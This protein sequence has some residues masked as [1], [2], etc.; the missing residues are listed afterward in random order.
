MKNH[1]SLAPVVLAVMSAM[2]VPTHA[3][4]L[5]TTAT[6]MSFANDQIARMADRAS[7]GLP[8]IQVDDE[9]W[10]AVK[11]TPGPGTTTGV[12]GY[13]TF[14][15][16]DGVQVVDVAYAQPSSIDA[17]G[18]ATIPMKGQSPIAI[19]AGSIGAK[20]ATGLTG[21]SYPAPN[22]LGVNEAPVTAGGLARG[23]IS[24]VYADTGIFYSTD[25][26]TAFNSYGAAP[27]GGSAPMTNNSGDTVGEWVAAG[28]PV[29]TMLGVMTLWDSYQLRAFGR[30]NSAPIIDTVDGRGNAPWGM[31]C[32]VAGPQSGYAWSFNAAYY[33]ANPTNANRIRNS[34]EVGPWQRVQYAGSQV[35][36]DQAGLLSTALGYSG[37]DASGMGVAP[38][39]IPYDPLNPVKAVRFAI[40]QLEFGRLEYS[41][42]KIRILGPQIAANYKMYADAF[43]G[44]AG[45]ADNGKDHIW[46]YFDPTVV[47]L[48]SSALLQK[49]AKNPLLAPGGTTSFAITFMNNA[50]TAMP[51]VVLTDT[52]PS[53]LSYLSSSPAASVS[54]STLTWS[55]GTVAAGQVVSLTVNV[56]ATTTGT[57]LNTVTATS[58]GT[59]VAYAQDTVEIGVRALLREVKTVTPSSVAP[60]EQVTYT[61]TVYNEGT[62]PNGVPMVVTDYLPSGFTYASFV[63]ATVNGA[64]ITPTINSSN[65]SQPTF[66]V[67]TAIQAGKTLVINFKALVG[68]S[69]PAG[70][71]YNQVELTFEGK[72]IPPIPEAP[73]IVTGGQIGG[74]VYTDT[75]ASGGQDAG[76]PGIPAVTVT[77]Y[78][79]LNNN[80][81]YDAGDSFAGTKVTDANGDYIFT[82]LLPGEYVVKINAPPAGTNTGNPPGG[83]GNPI[84][85]GAASLAL[86]GSVSNIDFGYQS[87]TT[88]SIG[89]Q[90]FHDVNNNG[91]YDAGDAALPNVT[92]QLYA[93]NGT[94]LLAT[95]TT[96]AGGLYVFDG[97]PAAT[98]VVKVDLTDPDLPTNLVSSVSA[99][100]YPAFALGAGQTLTDKDFPFVLRYLNKTVDKA[101]AVTGDILTFTLRSYHPGPTL[102]TNATVTDIVPAGTTYQNASANAGGSHAA[103]TVTWNLGSTAAAANGTKTLLGGGG[104]GI[105]QRGASTSATGSGASITVNKPAGVVAGDVMI[106]NIDLRGGTS[107][108]P[109]L[110]G[111]ST[112]ATANIEDGVLPGN[113]GGKEHRVALLYRVAN[114]TE[115]ASFTFALN[116]TVDDV[117]A[118]I[119][120]FSGVAN[121]GGL[122]AGGGPGVFD[123]AP[124][125]FSA[126]TSGPIAGVTAITTASA[127]AL[128]LMFAG[129]FDDA[130]SIT[131]F[132]TASMGALDS[133]SY[134]FNGSDGTIGAGWK[135]KASPGTTG[136]GSATLGSSKKW[137]AILLALRP[138][139]VSFNT[140]TALSANRSLVT[141]GDPVTVTLTVSA[142]GD[143]GT[144]TAGALTATGTNGA[145][146][147][148][149]AASPLTAT[150]NNGSATFTYTSTAVT[151]GTTPGVLTFEATPSGSIGGAWAKGTANTV[152][153]APPL[154]F[155][156]TV[157]TNPGVSAVT[158]TARL[159]NNNG[160]NLL[161]ESLPTNTVL[162]GSI[163]DHVWWDANRDQI[164]DPTELPIEDA[165]AMLYSDDNHNGIFDFGDTYITGTLTDANGDYSFP[166]LPAGPY[167]VDVYDDSVDEG[168]VSTT[169]LVRYHNLAPG[170]TYLGADFGYFLGARIE[171]DVFWDANR[172]AIFE[173][174]ETGL[175]PVTVTLNGTDMFNS[176]VSATTPTDVAG[177]F[178]FVVPEG[179]YTLTYSTPNVLVINSSLKDTT[180]PTSISFHA[181][182]GPYWL[183]APFTFGVDNSGK[184]GGTIF[185]DVINPGAL[186]S[187]EPGLSNITVELYQDNDNNNLVSAG[188]TLLDIQLTDADG[189]YLF[190]GLAGGNYVVNVLTDILSS[191]YDLPPTA[192]PATEWVSDSAAGATITLAG[193][194][195]LDRNFGYLPTVFVRTISGTVFHDFDPVNS[196]PNLPAEALPNVSVTATVDTNH[197]TIPEQVFTTTTDGNGFYQF[198]A[199]PV[200]CDAVITVVTTTLPNAAY[201]NT[202]DPDSTPNS[203]TGILNITANVTSQNFGYVVEYGSIAGTVVKG[204]GDGLAEPGEPARDGV[205]V[206]LTYAGADGILGTTTDDVI[207]TTVT[208]SN[209]DYTFANLLPGTYS[210]VTTVPAGFHPYADA[211]GFNPN[212][213]QLA[214]AVNAD[215]LNQDFEYQ[216]GSIGNSVWLDLNGNSTQDSGEPPL[217]N[218]RVYLDLDGNGSFDSAV[219]PNTTTNN[220]G[221][222]VISG[223]DAV[224]YTVRVDT[225]TLPPG[226]SPTYDLDGIGTPNATSVT[227][228]PNQDRT[229]VDFGYRGNATVTGH[230]YIDTNGNHSQDPGEPNLANVDVKVTDVLGNPQT[231]TTDVNGNW[232]VL[233]I[234]GDTTVKINELDPEYP[235][236]YTQTEGDD[237]TTVSAVAAASVSAGNDGFFLPGTISGSVL[238]D[239]DNNTTGDAPLVN[240]TITLTDGSGN[241]ID[242]DPGTPG[243]QATIALTDS[244][245]L[246]SFTNLPPGSYQVVETDPTGYASLTDN[247]VPVTLSAGGNEVANFVDTQLADL[248]ITKTDSTATYIPGTSTTY[249]IVVINN[250][251]NSVTG[252]TVADAL[253]A[254]I[255]SATWTTAVAGGASVLPATG[256]NDI[257]GTLNLPAGSSVTYT[258]VA[259]ISSSA[260]ADLVNTATVSV[261]NGMIDPTSG[262]NTATDTDTAAPQADLTI[263]KTDGTLTYVPGLPTTYTIIVSNTGPSAV[264]GA[265]VADTL[266]TDITG[267]T[268]TTAVT[269]GASVV[270]ATGTDDISGTLNLPAGSSVTY[271]VIA[272]ISSSATADLIN[273]ATVSVPNGVTDTTPGNNTA[274]DTDTAA[275]QADLTISKT[276]GTLTYVPGLPTTYTIIVSNTGPSA[277]TGATVADTL[278][279]DITGATWTTAVAGGASVV[280]ATGSNDISGTLNLPAGSSVTY[281]VIADISSSAT[282]DLI[283]TATVSVPNGVTDTTPGNNTATDTDT[284]AP[285]ADLTITK[286]DGTLTYVPGLPTTYTIIVSNTGPSA[287]TGATVADTLPTD[288]TGA[289][290][291]T[292]VAGGASVVPATGTDDISGTLN[293]PAGSSVTYTVIAD[294]SSSATADLINTAT[295]S[296]PNGVT[297]TTPGNNTAT[298]T[299]TAAPQADLTISKTDGTL[300]YV[301]GLPT[302]YTI[303]VSNTG[304]SAVTGATVADTLP[305]DITGATWTTAVAGGASVVPAT[306]TDDISGTLNLPAGSSVTY[307]VMADISSSATADLINTA[308]VSVPNGVTDTTPGNNT[309]TDTDTAAPQADLTIT[310]TDGTLTYVPGLP[311]TYTIIVSNTGPS[312]V[313]GATVADT[314]P[315]DITGATWTTAVAGGASVVPATGTDDISGTLNLPAGS[316]VT[317]TVIADISSS[318]TADLINTATV[319]VPNGVTDTTPGNNTATDTDTAAPQAD[320]TISKTDGTLTYVPGL[321]T[322]YTIIVSNTG[323]SAVTGATVADTLPTD[324]TGATWTT[325]VAGGASVVPATGT[326]DI[327]GTL[328][329]PA[330]SSVT[331]TVIADI[332]SS[333][334]ADLI[335]TATVSV[336]NGVTDTTPGNN[337]ATDTDT[338]APQADLTISKT[339]GTLTYVPGLPTT[340][341]IIVSNTGPSAVTG[342]TVA[343]TL[344]TDITGATW[345]TAVAGGA[346]VVPATGTDDIS[347][348]LNLPAGSSVTYT[349]IADISSSAT[350]DLINTATV[351]VPNGVTD[352]TPGN[353][354]ATDT[355]TAAPQADLTI[356]KTD[357]TLTYVPGL[358]TTYTIIVSNTGPSAV[359][360]ATVADTLPTDITGATWTTAVAGGASVVPATGSNDISGTLNLPAGSSVT[361]TVIADISSSATADLI[362]TATVSVPNGVTDTTPG[363]NTATDTDTAAPQADLTITKTDGTLTYVPGLPTT[364]TIIVSNTGPSAVTGA[365]VAD[366]LPTDITGAT[367]TTAVAGGASVVPATG[368]DDISGTL[369]LPAGSSVTYTVIADISSSATA[370]LINTA[371]VSVP[372]GVTDTT[373]GNNTATDTDTAAPQA[374]LTISKTDGTL[375]YVPGLPTTYT[376]IVSNTGPS[377]VTGATVA[378]TLPTDI[379]G[380]TWTTAV[381]GGASVVPAT[382]SNDISGTLNLP[383]GSSVTYTV[384]ADISSSATADLIN[385]A[386]VSVPNGVTDTTPGNNTATDTD[387][388]APQADLTISKT[389]GTLTYVPGL[390]TTYTIIVSNTGPSA[391]TGATVADTLPTDITGA[392]WTTAVAGGASVVP[393]TGTDDI[394][395]TLNLPAGSSVTYTVIADISSSATADLINTATVSVPNGVTDTTPGNNTATDTDTAAPQADLT[396]SKTDGTLTYV[397]G[398]PT[399]YTII[400]S[401]TGPSA[402]TG[403]TVADTLPT[404]ITGAT[405]TTAV[406]GGAS[407]VPA[408]GSN[409]ISGTLN[410]PAGSSVTYTVIAD[411]SSSATADLVNTAT[412]SVPNGVTDTTPGN[413]TATDTD[414]A[415]P[416]ADLTISKT[417]GTL[418]Y[419]PG[420]PTTYTIIVSNT[421]P[422]AVT[423]ATVADT[424]PTDITGAT[425]TT[426]VTGGASVVPAT[427]TDDISGTLNL[428]A[429]SSVTY[430]VIADISSSATADLINTATVSVPNG[431]TDTT[432]GNNT[433]T[434]T[435]TAAPQADLTIT[436]TDGTLTYVPGLPTTYTIIVRNTGPSAVTGATVADTLPTDITGATWTTAVTGGASVLP[437]TGSNDISG[438]LNLP[439]NSSVTYTVVADISSSATADLVN[440][441][442]VSVPNGVT[443]T[444]PGNNTATDTDTAAPQADLTI[445]KTDGTLTYVPGLPTTYTIIVSNTGP[446]AVT[447]ATVA[448]TLPTDITGATWTT[449]V[450]GGASVVPATGTDDISG[451]L[452]LPAGSSVTYTVIADISSSATADLINTATVS[453]PN[454]VTD[455]TPG[456]NTATDT[457]TATPR[458]DLSISKTVDKYEPLVGS[459][460]VFTLDASNIGPSDAT[461]VKVTDILPGGYTFVSA[462]PLLAYNSTTGIW[463]IGSLA[464]NGS[465]TL[466]ITAKVKAAGS[467]DNIA[468]IKGDQ[469]DPQPD[470]DTDN[471]L[472]EP[473]PLGYITGSV[474]DDTNNDNTSLIGIADVPLAL[475]DA[476]GNDI[477]S[478]PVTFGMQP[479]VTTTAADGS[480]GFADLPPGS[481]RVV[482]T[483]PSGYL[484]V[485][486]VDGGN[487]DIIGDNVL[488]S[489][490]PGNT[491]ANQNFVEVRVG[492]LGNMVWFDKNHNGVFDSGDTGLAGVT[493]T[494]KDDSH[495]DIDSDP[496]APG[497]QPTSVITAVDGTYHFPNLYPGDYVVYLPATPQGLPG[498]C[499][500]QNPNDDQKDN[501]NNGDQPVLGGPVTSPVIHIDP[502]ENDP[503]IDIGFTCLGTW[504]EWQFLHP[505]GGNNQPGANPDSDNYDNL[506]EYAFRLEANSGQG[507][508]F[509]LKPSTIAT[510]KMEFTFNRPY[511]VTAD[512]TYYLEYN[513]SLSK[514]SSWITIPLSTMQS[515]GI[516]DIV[517]TEPCTETVTVRN[518]EAHEG[519]VRL[520]VDLDSNGDHIIERTSRTG[521][522][523]WTESA[524]ELGKR[525]YNNPYPH[526]DAFTGTVDAVDGNKLIFTTSA[527][528]TNM[529]DVLWP[530]PLV[531]PRAAYYLE[532]TSGDNE[533]QRFDVVSA[534][535]STVTLV[536]NDSDLFADTPPFNTRTGTLPA[537]LTGARVAIRRHWTLA[538]LFPVNR[539]FAAGD[540]TTADQVQTEAH[541]ITT[542]YWLYTNA[543][544]P[545]WAKDGDLTLTDRAATVIAPGQGMFVVKQS[546][547]IALMA[548]GEVRENKFVRPLE[549]GFNLVGGGYP[550]VQSATGT[551]TAT[552][553]VTATATTIGSRQMDLVHG[554]FGT[555]DFATADRFSVWKGDTTIGAT[556]YDDYY[557]LH[558]PGA[559]PKWVKATDATL[560]PRD[561]EKL[562]LGN[563]SVRIR[564][565]NSQPNYTI[566]NPWA[567]EAPTTTWAQWQ[568]TNLAGEAL[569][570]PNDDPDHDGTPNLLEY[571]FGTPSRVAQAPTAMPL[572]I[573]TVGGQRFLQITIPRL[574]DHPAVLSVEVSSDLTH[575]QA[576]PTFTTVVSDG[577]AALV[578]R[579]LTPLVAGAPMRFMRLVA[580]VS[581]P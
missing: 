88:G 6:S 156:A 364:Y 495:N 264:T 140:T 238:A 361:Y 201:V 303:I 29:N 424:L 299:D 104:G 115:G 221:N 89:D 96:D 216:A 232:S 320:L 344:P 129:T 440:T 266:P 327:S 451:T 580:E 385:T 463:S 14:Y 386:T 454:G 43:G 563:R 244:N 441:A 511:G 371:T 141:S 34:I 325:A 319:S 76:E 199:I 569:N 573:V 58:N 210:I 436:K 82:G 550:V 482:E 110:A 487:L 576:G 418:T 490:T 540:S 362:N 305:T 318:A 355:D 406:A 508:P 553:I 312:A 10:I 357:G 378:D 443:D 413:N 568:V 342:A 230:L 472:T 365:T 394:S 261:P 275:P 19:G 500:Q 11:T 493:V 79:D 90:V 549:A 336:P 228:A 358:P 181:E 276:D 252:A 488:I 106:V 523:G 8:P 450:A 555:T 307:T 412:V 374:D 20:A 23:T 120:A 30:K 84:N 135:V 333:A 429:G 501:D 187:G 172:D 533:G 213:I 142:T 108:Y 578:V 461:G 2:A 109:S 183:H 16:P 288:I 158:N 499:P 498:L 543:G 398:L 526:Y 294:I 331:Y 400:V 554:F 72:R 219:E 439:A 515:K 510:S 204:D 449:A 317:Y 419:V 100:A 227:L 225:S 564:M 44:D 73:V 241:N 56:K 50:A 329:L 36:K 376:I 445:S 42:V 268:W 1:R 286:T 151:A 159:N 136:A 290:W 281:T 239:T 532:V 203:T 579:D 409:D 98:Y 53:G 101:T 163:G 377:A 161:Q 146:A 425:W 505:L 395:G 427:G 389:D 287:V 197:D 558:N 298:D 27:S 343:D 453:V 323:P 24:G 512:V 572:E 148:F 422:S 38:T 247:L 462:D 139:A 209:G 75:N 270:P 41:A 52:L 173:S 182:A 471:A 86:N 237:P 535:G 37:I 405:W 220:S 411:I 132:A 468:S 195:V 577:P 208:D 356:S 458:A 435:D 168:V 300:T 54:G 545:I 428:P 350:A 248:A 78:N 125:S 215:V 99:G 521:T 117:A 64:T 81:I 478:D 126:G 547:A 504:Q 59:F 486:D 506:I 575:W 524:M 326:D 63:N 316:S 192:H 561:A 184:I 348:T 483:Q 45:G 39:A 494:L 460:V 118:A 509:W 133:G 278:P 94:T 68:P 153:I 502:A 272:D 242:S 200:G 363:N 222:Y 447:G 111:W 255:T 459:Q 527:G 437:A 414:T 466:H 567:I 273:T 525:T 396:I 416:Q 70:T 191:A 124:G 574:A 292:A 119:V 315:T 32:A 144:V 85:E 114:G 448:D 372:N 180:T 473:I 484:S 379:T 262:N 407:V 480:Y 367:W 310:K 7:H 522:Q 233:V 269:G 243:I 456:N 380:A 5:N 207:F 122:G 559:D 157:N 539:F 571:V 542:T 562:F 552:A 226:T 354:T 267:A 518:F 46:R 556:T 469:F 347:G 223:L 71:Y 231:V 250:G 517:Q 492:S 127:N 137:G 388:A 481:Y 415:A 359:T 337:T 503:T 442:T 384:I 171:G 570:G 284:A 25:A 314:L 206:T 293:L 196:A 67:G 464:L 150:V 47:S 149:G 175:S 375:T 514:T 107:V 531:L 283:N 57:L 263:S 345:T 253:P 240:V 301:P 446:S 22:I 279:T 169:P 321:P 330:G 61:M 177:H 9:F 138:A 334:T 277:V 123:V 489:V 302:T 92:V 475:K 537:S 423:G 340:Y 339:D 33:D 116:T 328:N 430:T 297:D 390:P 145:A 65:P 352:T 455:T 474:L 190:V 544:S 91:G 176:P 21:Y 166:N 193:N 271:T 77:L 536:E 224:T 366:T 257:S 236:G 346:S 438:T 121:S 167:F 306:G 128:V 49:V 548:Y 309:A 48:Q 179:N 259:D 420:L 80:D 93:A 528:F 496:V 296:V 256:S 4:N 229:D 529:D 274:T 485:S 186:D 397:P 51:N 369:N 12:G 432:P 260:T 131:T 408:T 431:V 402:V 74:T 251:P 194:A 188:D 189:K 332:S 322:T 28:F 102:L 280:P 282:A 13:Q 519:F 154:T 470:N 285:Q 245:G 403:A 66:T 349:V 382:G 433:A 341:T 15:V 69:T 218:V 560:A 174:G 353:N 444:T 311:T 534:I 370:D 387:T 165:F 254:E 304:P 391:V 205:T 516:V 18:F 265:T 235:T 40:G 162:L 426:A 368:S 31:G 130:T 457:D 143:A 134:S 308:T 477:D 465:A 26:R 87:S 289:T 565:N 421:G 373:P 291:T 212:N 313:T 566:P 249:T 198:L 214:L 581:T 381:A 234:A 479:T 401:N 105:A 452:N 17:R 383:A 185:A 113:G 399:T 103:G 324:I 211:D 507:T 513:S 97:R 392:T 351:S 541:G 147:T 530:K 164:V 95:T 467:Y 360:G 335:N 258:L 202:V 246:Y 546:T 155:A 417:D 170:E 55:L 152:L 491:T 551:G 62:G 217:A 112:I 393:A 160:A 404:D 83:V 520:R 557:Y 178:A 295:V 60:G 35:S 410:L 338:A 497:V 3:H 434:D 476:A 538:E